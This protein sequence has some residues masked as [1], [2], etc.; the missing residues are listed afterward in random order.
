M[1]EKFKNTAIDN[2]IN[3][4]LSCSESVVKAAADSGLV[5]VELVNV[6]TSFSGGMSSRCACGAL[7]G[8]QIVIGYIHGKLKDNTARE[9]AAKMYTEFCAVH[10]VAC[11]KVLSS[12]FKDFHSKE[13]KLHCVNMIESSCN[14]LSE[15][16]EELKAKT[17]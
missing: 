14:I 4:G 2:F 11:C 17:R 9:L 5:P 13:R 3:Q 8:A 16:L 10:K 12:G 1:K 6:A 7:T 15:I